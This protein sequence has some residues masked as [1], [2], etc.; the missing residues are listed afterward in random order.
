MACVTCPAQSLRASLDV[1][2]N[3]DDFPVHFVNSIK[4]NPQNMNQVL[5]CR[6]KQQCLVL[7]SPTLVIKGD[8]T[9][10][11]TAIT[12]R[13]CS[14]SNN[15]PLPSLVSSALL[16]SVTAVATSQWLEFNQPSSKPRGGPKQQW[17]SG[18]F[19]NEEHGLISNY[20]RR[21]RQTV[22]TLL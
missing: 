7:Q 20:E 8:D 3:T 17:L 21:A 14:P 18:E 19:V 9:Q 10:R 15:R 5:L 11:E 2:S 16:S 12:L 1:S 6:V 4:S 22:L 13:A